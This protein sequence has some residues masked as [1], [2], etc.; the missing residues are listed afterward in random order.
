MRVRITTH[1]IELLGAYIHQQTGVFLDARK[2]YLFE[3]RLSPLLVE[4]GLEDYETLYLEVCND[5]EG[6]LRERLISAITTDETSFFR[7]EGYYR[8]LADHVIPRLIRTKRAENPRRPRIAIWCAA[9]SR[10]Q[11]PYSIAMLLAE[12]LVLPD[13]DIRI[14]ATDIS[15]KALGYAARGRYTKYELSR[16][17]TMQRL[18][19]F[20]VAED[21]VW[22]IRDDLRSLVHFQTMNLLRDA[23]PA[24]PVDL[25]LCRNVAVYFTAE[26]RRRLFERVQTHMHA[27]SMLMVGAT[28]TL[29]EMK[30]LT[31]HVNGQGQYYQKAKHPVPRKV[32]AS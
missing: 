25:I 1:E 23:P 19:R 14:F 6:G 8:C 4:L 20:F 9:C 2:A 13:Y 32:V 18:E 27:E 30:T 12:R 21:K 7:D 10:G 31:C 22:R 5:A 16:G 17:M 26:D 24:S 28:E 11:E 29:F 3:Y 15:E